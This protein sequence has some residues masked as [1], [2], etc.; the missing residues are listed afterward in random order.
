MNLLDRDL[1][2]IAI[3]IAYLVSIVSFSYFVFYKKC[4]CNHFKRKKVDDKPENHFIHY[5]ELEYRPIDSDYDGEE[6]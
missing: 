1:V 2:F 5:D 6:L 3:C 4:I